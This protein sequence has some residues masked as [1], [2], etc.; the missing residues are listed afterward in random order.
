MHWITSLL[1]LTMRSL[2]P[3]ETRRLINKSLQS[4]TFKELNH[5]THF[6]QASNLQQLV[7]GDNAQLIPLSLM[8]ANT[9]IGGLNLGAF[10]NDRL[11]G[12]LFSLPGIW[13]NEPVHWSY[14]LAIH[15]DYQNLKVG[16][17]LKLKQKDI[18]RDKRQV[19]YILW[20][21]DPLESRNAYFNCH[22]LGVQ[23]IDYLTDFY[24]GSTSDLH[25]DLHTDRLLV[26]WPLSSQPPRP[27]FK[28]EDLPYYID[29]SSLKTSPSLVKLKIP[30]DIQS[31]KKDNLS[32]A[33]NWQSKIKTA[34]QILSQSEYTIIDCLKDT[35][36][37]HY[38]YIFKRS[39]S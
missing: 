8:K 24:E 9:L 10:V 37:V 39:S 7:W 20:S 32:E 19:N 5:A 2:D 38:V 33:N 34:F 31:L 1:E 35:H 23:V 13:K 36:S 11:I 21:F 17:S 15:P 12:F 26:K 25:Q 27:P 14:R 16:Q 6:S 29:S 22:K 28:L 30:I 18:C 3:T 4:I